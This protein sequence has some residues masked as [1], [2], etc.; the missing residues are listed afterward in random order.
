MIHSGFCNNR[1]S[2]IE[3]LTSCTMGL[4]FVKF[5]VWLLVVSAE[6]KVTGRATCEDSGLGEPARVT[7][8]YRENI[9]EARDVT[10][11]SLLRDTGGKEEKVVE[12]LRFGNN[13]FDCIPKDGYKVN[14]TISDQMII[15]IP[16]ARPEHQGTY[17]CELRTQQ[18]EYQM[19]SCDL[20]YKELDNATTSTQ[21][22]EQDIDDQLKKDTGASNGIAWPIAVTVI[23]VLLVIVVLVF[24]VLF[25]LRRRRRE[26]NRRHDGNGLR[27][28]NFNQ[29]PYDLC[30]VQNLPLVES[31]GVNVATAARPYCS[32]ISRKLSGNN[33]NSQGGDY[34]ASW[35]TYHGSMRRLSQ[36]N[37]ETDLHLDL[38]LDKLRRDT[39]PELRHRL[40]SM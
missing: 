2:A 5:I 32:K 15:N 24:A 38:D 3:C 40:N 9:E 1:K 16:R 22:S 37:L 33:A 4:C 14:G 23:L 8:H 29:F 26:R 36:L 31:T 13:G 35:V 34:K 12:C 21:P 17:Y 30:E 27:G 20:E 6:G 10:A 18:N 39:K 19:E 11:V 28:M 7:C 25:V